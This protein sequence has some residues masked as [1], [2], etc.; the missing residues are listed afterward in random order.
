MIGVIL[1]TNPKLILPWIDF[2]TAYDLKDYPNFKLGVFIALTTAVS[3]GFAY[4]AMRKM[5]T[6][7]DPT[8]STFHYGAF[9]LLFIAPTM[10][11]LDDHL[12]YSY[13]T[14]T[15]IL[16]LSVMILGFFSQWGINKSLAIGR[17]GPMAAINYLQVVMAWV[18]DV[19]FFGQGIVVTDVIGTLCIIGCTIVG[20]IVEAVGKKK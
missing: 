13:D 6:D 18:S 3:S 11:V 9:C 4:L 5:G 2:E 1:M 19:T 10:L 16:M 20:Y 14:L 12:D 8:A 15:T 7:I 17:A